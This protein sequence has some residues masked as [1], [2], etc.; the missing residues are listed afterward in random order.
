M[1]DFMNSWAAEKLRRDEPPARLLS[2]WS[3]QSYPDGGV[4][5]HN[6]S[7]LSWSSC[8]LLSKV[9]C[10]HFALAGGH[11]GGKHQQLVRPAGEVRHEG[12]PHKGQ[13]CAV[14]D[15]STVAL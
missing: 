13:T 11:H 5:I 10:G 6:L 15:M 4:C 12:V 7:T 9:Q 3:Q 1:P 14:P 8:L 2:T